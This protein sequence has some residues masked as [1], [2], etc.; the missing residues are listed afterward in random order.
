VALAGE[1]AGWPGP[2]GGGRAGQ[3]GGAA[4]GAGRGWRAAP[5]GG[6]AVRAWRPPAWWRLLLPSADARN[7][8]THPNTHTQERNA[9][10]IRAEGESESAK[11]I[12]E[13]TKA[14]GQGLIEL[15][16]IEV[17]CR[18]RMLDP[19]DLVWGQLAAP[20]AAAC[21]PRVGGGAACWGCLQLWWHTTSCKSAAAGASTLSSMEL[22]AA[23][24][25]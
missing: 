3:R 1:Q 17:R 7:T 25:R 11:L 6:A 14:A 15:R 13:A 2:A 9:A 23:L 4:R 10:V 22:G 21:I 24:R 18:A 12:S 19:A 16:R 20:G 8:P 5:R